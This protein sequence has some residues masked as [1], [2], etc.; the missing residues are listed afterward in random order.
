VAGDKF[1]C[2]YTATSETL[3]REHASKPGFPADRI[4]GVRAAIDP[5]TAQPR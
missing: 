1:Y 3:I 5:T 2:V 4:T